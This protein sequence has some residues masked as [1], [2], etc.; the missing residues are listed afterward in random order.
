MVDDG[1]LIVQDVLVGLVEIEPL[2][3]DDWLS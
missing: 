2:F 1:D 3:E